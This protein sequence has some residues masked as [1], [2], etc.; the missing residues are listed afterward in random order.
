M[1]FLDH[2]NINFLFNHWGSKSVEGSLVLGGLT[3]MYILE[4]AFKTRIFLLEK[5]K[6]FL[7]LYFKTEKTPLINV[8]ESEVI[9]KGKS[10]IPSSKVII[11]PNGL[12][13]MLIQENGIFFL[14]SMNMIL[15]ELRMY[16][17][18]IDQKNVYRMNPFFYQLYS[19][20]TLT[21][22]QPFLELKDLSSTC[23]LHMILND[24]FAYKQLLKNN[25][26]HVE[27]LINKTTF[28]SML[29]TVVETFNTDNASWFDGGNFHAIKGFFWGF[30]NNEKKMSI[31][32]NTEEIL[33]SIS[34]ALKR[35][36][37]FMELISIF[38]IK[39]DFKNDFF[40]QGTTDTRNN[41]VVNL[42]ILLGEEFE[43]STNLS[44]MFKIDCFQQN[45]VLHYEGNTDLKK[46]WKYHG[47]LGYR[48]APNY[49]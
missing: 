40:F 9:A 44:T 31:S 41:G 37:F 39:H 4:M 13:G 6:E 15:Y 22:T 43:L 46:L 19:K 33:I 28:Q 8:D 3:S 48:T 47:K 11:V 29:K 49:F 30:K 35:T 18:T 42:K 25:T 14:E 32:K 16:H 5:I 24:L 34:N 17:H 27:G 20:N 21:R 36:N 2:E 38:Q 1:T 10:I 26:T 45:D 12:T 23:L 7:N